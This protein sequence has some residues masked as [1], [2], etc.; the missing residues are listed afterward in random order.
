MN[1]IISLAPVVVLVASYGASGASI[2]CP[3]SA[4]RVGDYLQTLVKL[5]DEGE[6]SAIQIL[7]KWAKS[8]DTQFQVILLCR[9]LF[10]PSPGR[11]FRRPRLGMGMGYPW[12]STSDDWPL[13]PITIYLNVPFLIAGGYSSIGRAE[14]AAEY[15]I[16][17]R[18]ECQWT[19]NRYKVMQDKELNAI[20]DKFVA[21][22]NWKI[23]AMDRW[24]IPRIR[25]YFAN[26]IWPKP[27]TPTTD[28]WAEYTK[29]SPNPLMQALDVPQ[30]ARA[31]T[32]DRNDFEH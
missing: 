17:C 21:Q 12:G 26:Q 18:S 30:P 24:E 14:T 6:D 20:L 7:E 29:Y 1:T 16:Y 10:E 31:E 27:C 13:D 32:E 2:E 11:T 22:T 3:K 15:L 19:K 9:M 5:Q 28:W 23:P 4:F 8:S 25:A